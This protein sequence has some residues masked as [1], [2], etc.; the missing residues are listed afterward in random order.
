MKTSRCAV[1]VLLTGSVGCF[2]V[3]QGSS[4]LDK[5]D[6]ST[7][8]KGQ[9]TREHLFDELGNPQ[10]ATLGTDG[11][12]QDGWTFHRDTINIFLFGHRTRGPVKT[13]DTTVRN[14]VVQDYTT[15]G[16]AAR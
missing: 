9:T 12:E 13:L 3:P 5:F 4:R 6:A 16:A 1:A 15:G 14:G 7:I 11:S 10:R 8:V 2:T